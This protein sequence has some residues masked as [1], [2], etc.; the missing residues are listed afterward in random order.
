MLES[1]NIRNFALIEDLSIDFG[2]GFNVLSGET[3]AGKSIII[4]AL[5]LILGGKSSS[6]MVRT[7]A[8][9]AS[10]EG[11]FS[12]SPDSPPVQLLAATG[13]DTPSG[14]LVIRR[15]VSA[16]GKSRCFVNGVLSNMT[17]LSE[18]GALL[19]DIHG[20][21]ENQSL[22]RI[23]LHLGLLDEFAGLSGRVDEIRGISRDLARL[24]EQLAALAMDDREKARRLELNGHAIHEI[25]GAGLKENEEGELEEES[26]L[27]ANFEKIH[28][29]VESACDALVPA[30]GEVRSAAVGLE[31]AGE[32]DP[33]LA[34]LAERIRDAYYSLEDVTDELRAWRGRIDFS[35]ER[36]EEVNE[37][38]SLIQSLK[39]KYG[40]SVTQILAFRDKA[41]EE[42]E[43]IQTSDQRRA[44]LAGEIATLQKRAAQMALALS[45][46]RQKRAREMETR[47][48]EE[49]AFLGMAR[50]VFKV[51]IRYVRDSEGFVEV[52]GE[53]I[54]LFETGV[55]YVEFLVSPNPGEEARPLRKIASGGEMSRIML[56]MKSVLSGRNDCETLVFDEVD[57]GIGGVTASAVGKK[58]RQVS[59][60]HQVLC[61]THLPQIAAMA[62]QHIMVSKSIADGRTRTQIRHLA[63][64]ERL[65]ELAR[66]LGGEAV[67]ETTLQQAREMI[68]MGPGR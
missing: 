32:H 20:Q 43:S 12:V 4:G 33:R 23:S 49:L 25:D 21:H 34:G 28:S 7:G 55:D 37:R 31:S 3:G 68:E 15:T 46:E 54:R 50:T 13:I 41:A 60:G 2:R 64:D 42:N 24:E 48:M 66:M 52:R 61:I 57:A 9:M 59:E 16:D 30:A 62:D 22:L 27:L 47:V 6:E 18:L 29:A 8:D 53:R 14:E 39:R 65:A 19:V 38:I 10:I 5:G 35:P 26:R 1:L 11:L 51:D 58:L 44:E 36:L 63:H 56:A 45:Q 17:V 40:E 67:S